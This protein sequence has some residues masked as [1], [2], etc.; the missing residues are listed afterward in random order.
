V[1][2]WLALLVL[3]AG[4]ALIAGVA[5]HPQTAG[6]LY[7]ASMPFLAGIDRG[8]VVPLL[9]PTELLQVALTAAAWSGMAGAWLRRR[10]EL[11]VDQRGVTAFRPRLTH[12]DVA[13]LV[14]ALCGSLV[15]LARLGLVG[16]WQDGHGFKP[17]SGDDVLACIPLWKTFGLYF[18]FRTTIR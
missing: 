14:L 12:L 4:V 1:T 13:L 2:L 18:L 15:P 16:I 6:P 11:S 5:R 9:R 8:R 10:A 3:V 7:L 17:I